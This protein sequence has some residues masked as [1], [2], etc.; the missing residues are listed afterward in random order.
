MALLNRVGHGELMLLFGLFMALIAGGHVFESV[1]LKPDLGALIPGTLI[2][3]HPRS[4]EMADALRSIKDILMIGF[5][6]DT[7]LTGLPDAPGLIATGVL[8]LLLDKKQVHIL[9]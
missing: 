3:K 2:A 5:F 9:G 8:I 6:L 1:S 7:G 4:R